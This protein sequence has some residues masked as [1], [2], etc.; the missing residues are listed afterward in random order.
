MGRW[1]VAGPCRGPA[2]GALRVR[3]LV[4]VLLALLAA[5]CSDGK[6]AAA[7]DTTAVVAETTT[8]TTT[9][10]PAPTTAKPTTTSSTLKPT[11]TSSTLLA[12]GPGEASIVGTVSG[13]SG[14]VDGAIVRVERLVGKLVVSTDATTAGGGTYSVGMVFGGSYR[15]RAF[16]PPDFASSPVEAFFLAANERKVLDLRMPSAGGE[17]ITATVSPNPPKVDQIATL[18]IQVGT[19]RVDDQGRPAVTPR[20]GV[21]LILTPAA[22]LALEGTPQ[23]LTDGNGSAAWRIRCLAE[24][25]NTF[26]LTVG[27][28]ITQVKIPACAAGAPPPAPTTTRQ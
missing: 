24:G 19:G 18:T 26:Q 20:P 15:V 9:A 4:V 16:K 23:A 7:P 11:T 2:P 28:G 3:R 12:M 13:P 22:G 1:L 5:A 10:A 21:P 14:P 25:A 27:A 6:P 8:S 17:R